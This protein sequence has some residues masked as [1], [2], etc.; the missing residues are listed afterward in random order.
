M[1]IGGMDTMGKSTSTILKYNP[2]TDSWE[3]ISNIPTARYRSLVAVLPINIIET[4]VVGGNTSV[5]TVTGKVEVA[6]I[7][8]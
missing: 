8:L 1:A 6:N 3:I 4:M 2:T 7:T 5:S